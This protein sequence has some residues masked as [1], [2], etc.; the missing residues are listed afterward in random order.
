GTAAIDV[1]V[2]SGALDMAGVKAVLD[3]LAKLTFRCIEC[4]QDDVRLP[5][6]AL[7]NPR[8]CEHCRLRHRMKTSS[9]MIA[10]L[11]T[12]PT[13][14]RPPRPPPRPAPGPGAAPPRLPPPPRSGGG[15]GGGSPPT[16]R[17]L[18]SRAPPPTPAPPGRKKPP[19][20][21]P[22]TLRAARTPSSSPTRSAAS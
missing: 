7:P 6:E 16:P 21:R 19:L 22:P 9:G 8:P 5:E 15:R 4:G 20:L 1:L 2:A 14:P 3:E 11:Q 17:S 12:P 18:R 13:L 10:P